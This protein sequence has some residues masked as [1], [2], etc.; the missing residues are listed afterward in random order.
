MNFLFEKMKANN[1]R[2]MKQDCGLHE[3]YWLATSGK[4]DKSWDQYLVYVLFWD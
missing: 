2:P 1:L 4:E 3:I